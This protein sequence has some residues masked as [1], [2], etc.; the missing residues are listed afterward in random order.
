MTTSVGR[1]AVLAGVAGALGVG[2]GCAS[3]VGEGAP[4]SMLVAGSLTNAV[5]N[6]LRPATD[7]ALRVEARGSAHAARLV[8]SGAKDPDVLS[9]ADPALFDGLDADWHAAF[10]TNALV[11][12]YNADTPG[13]RRVARADDWYRPLLRDD[14]RFGRTDPDL[15]PLGYRTLFALELA[16]DHYDADID[17]RDA[18]PSRD[19]LY[20]ETQLVS[21]FET[22]GIDAAITYR[23]MVHDRGYDY[24]P[25]PPAVNLSDPARADRYARTT[26]ELP[27]GTVV[28]GDVIRYAAT[29]RRSS[30]AVRETFRRHVAGDYLSAFGFGVP[31]GYPRFTPHA[32]DE[33]AH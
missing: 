30:P 32:P 27:D 21:Q 28:R 1:R 31:D 24:R 3:V 4:V 7:R 20:P 10:A 26:Y 29:V 2:A 33:L 18:I 9:L 25:L 22:G 19:Q 16:T 13:G 6:G 5:E 12:A 8:A 23:T 14:V 15:D 11:L 17:L